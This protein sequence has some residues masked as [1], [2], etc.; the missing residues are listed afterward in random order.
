MGLGEMGLGHLAGH[1]GG[2]H[3]LVLAIWDLV[4]KRV[5]GGVTAAPIVLQAGSVE[6]LSLT[7]VA[8]ERG[9]TGCTCQTCALTYCSTVWC[10]QHKVV[11]PMD[12]HHS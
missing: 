8:E 3:E 10:L 6:V 11:C 12:C 5:D 7:P 1:P 9:E 4:V 2:T